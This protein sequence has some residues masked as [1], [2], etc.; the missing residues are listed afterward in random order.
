MQKKWVIVMKT[1]RKELY[2]ILYSLTLFILLLLLEKLL[3]VCLSDYFI[4]EL[5]V[6]FISKAITRV[7]IILS[8]L[9][10]INRFKLKKYN[11]LEKNRKIKNL[12]SLLFPSLFI[13][14]GLMINWNTYLDTN[15]ATL[16]L[17]TLSVFSVGFAEEFLFRGIIFPLF[18]RY[19]KM[20]KNV[21]FLSV[22]L[23][24]SIFGVAHYLNLIRE[25]NNFL[26]V[27]SQVVFAI[28]IGIFLGGLMLRTENILIPSIFHGFVNFSFDTT[29]LKTGGVEF[30]NDTIKEGVNWNSMITTTLFFTFILLGGV[31]MIKKVDKKEILLKLD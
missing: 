7:V 2:N 3:R 11:G 24:S 9:W 8:L 4:I 16:F 18:I 13:L 29:Q 14:M 20:R 28:S 17:F 15:R 5:N 30:I 12:Q 21:L 6:E 1:K 26:G 31:Y 10:L 19:F 27:T 23:S 22:V 25:P